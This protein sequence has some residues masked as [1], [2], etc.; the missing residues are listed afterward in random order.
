M[1]T[2]IKN[3]IN[4]VVPT[5]CINLLKANSKDIVLKHTI[6]VEKKAKEL[7]ARFGIDIRSIRYPGLISANLSLRHTCTTFQ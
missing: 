7:G 6:S 1:F 5:D 3:Q 2:E 4:G